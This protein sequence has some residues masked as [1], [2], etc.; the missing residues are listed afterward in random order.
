MTRTYPCSARLN[1]GDKLKVN[2]DD[3]EYPDCIVFESIGGPTALS[4]SR[5]AQLAGQLRTWLLGSPEVQQADGGLRE[6]LN[7]FVGAS[8]A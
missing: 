3:P 5:A 2:D 6:E 4:R 8:V 1:P 7:E